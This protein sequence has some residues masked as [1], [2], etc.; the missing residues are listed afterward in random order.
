LFSSGTFALSVP[1]L[2]EL[3]LLSPK[4]FSFLIATLTQ[5]SLGAGV[6]ATFE[7]SYILHNSYV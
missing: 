7:V 6:G 2:P 4:F 5:S 1:E 3:G